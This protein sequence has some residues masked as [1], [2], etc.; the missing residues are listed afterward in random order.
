MKKR[1]RELNESKRRG[2]NVVE[3]ARSGY[4]DS[5]LQSAGR[6]AFTRKSWWLHPQLKREFAGSRDHDITSVAMEMPYESS[7][8]LFAIITIEMLRGWIVS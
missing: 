5:D 8:L 2:D 3:S 7:I 1:P 4:S 6:P